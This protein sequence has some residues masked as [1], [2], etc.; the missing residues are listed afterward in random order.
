MATKPMLTWALLAM[1]RFQVGAVA[2]IVLPEA[3]TS[4]FQ[5]LCR[6][7]PEGTVKVTVQGVCAGPLFSTV[8]VPWNP[9]LQE[10]TATCAVQLAV[11]AE[12][13][14]LAVG[15]VDGLVVGFAVGLVVGLAVGLVVGCGSP[16]YPGI[17]ITWP[18]PP[19]KTT[20]EQP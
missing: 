19:S 17:P 20:S 14:G 6:V 7:T 2:V 3:V 5:P 9:P 12:P 10:V 4:A 13:V 1:V 18:F 8:T 11:P 15:L 16:P